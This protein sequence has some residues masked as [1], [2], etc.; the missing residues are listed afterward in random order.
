MYCMYVFMSAG[1]LDD[2]RNVTVTKT[3][4]VYAHSS[5]R[6]H[7]IHEGLCTDTTTNVSMAQMTRNLTISGTLPSF[8]FLRCCIR[9]T[10]IALLSSELHSGKYLGFARHA[11]PQAPGMM[12]LD[13]GL[14]KSVT[15]E[16]RPN[17]SARNTYIHVNHLLMRLLVF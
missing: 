10:V 15:G 4:R 17:L 1:I 2:H 5:E 9:S 7:R 8:L 14:G 11:L 6:G 3:F 12:Q 16:M 13:H